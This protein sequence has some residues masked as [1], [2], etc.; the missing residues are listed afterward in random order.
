MRTK[1]I[2]LT[3]SEKQRFKRKV[4]KHY[5]NHG[6]KLP[7]RETNN[8]YH[9]LVSVFIKTFPTLRS[10]AKA[11]LDKL[12]R[13]W[14]G[15]GYNRRALMLQKCAQQIVK[16]Y[17]GVIPDTPELLKKLPG[18]GKA[19]SASICAFAFNKPV[20]FIETNIRTVFIYEFFPKKKDVTDDELLP[21]VAQALDKINSY[22]WYS[23]IMDY[24]AHLKKRHPNPSRKSAHHSRQS[25]FEGSD[26]QIRGKVLK[27]LLNQNKLSFAKLSEKVTADTIRF[28]RILKGLAEEGFIRYKNRYYSII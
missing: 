10:L 7:W 6:R 4:Y 24:G 14:Q 2:K 8:P 18:L 20:I 22:T 15:L 9:I 1:Q 3:S 17:K 26:R 23:A 27:I 11:P 13:T 28:K 21:L 5:N 16:E 25:K 12:L 19:T